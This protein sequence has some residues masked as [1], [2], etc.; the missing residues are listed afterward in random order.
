M[1]INVGC[2][3][4]PTPGWRNFDNSPSLRL[5]SIAVL[6]DLLHRL[7]LLNRAQYQFMRF[8]RDHQIEYGD[9]TK[10]LPVGEASV[11]VLYSSHMLEHLDR[12]EASEFLREAYRILRPG[13]ILRIAVPDLERQIA[14]YQES[15][16]ADAFVEGMHLC[17]SR[18]RSLAGRLSLLVTGTR[19][20]QWM[21]DGRSLSRLL[22]EHG[23][24]KAEVLPAGQTRIDSPGALDLAE[25]ASESL[26]VEAE[27]PANV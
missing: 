11:D 10:G 8:A 24:V 9:A 19:H 7:G 17:V 2:G 20:H 3:Q 25:R 6:P 27:K 21:Y 15:G 23:F 14:E 1:R 18:P 5:A 13:G 16:D 4:T 12:R 22:Q 26:Y